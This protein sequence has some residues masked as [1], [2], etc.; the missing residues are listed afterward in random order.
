ML[1]LFSF[2][3]I[4]AQQ[5]DIISGYITDSLSGEALPG[6]H[7]QLEQT[8]V[9]TASNAYGFYSLGLPKGFS[10]RLKVSAVGYL[11]VWISIGSRLGSYSFALTPIS[12][13]LSEVTVS[14][15]AIEPMDKG[16]QLVI[17]PLQIA[18]FPRLLSEA[19]PLKYLQ[20]LPGIKMGREGSAGL[21]VRGGTPDQNLMVLDG[22]PIYNANHL[23]GYLSVFN[24]EAINNIEVYKNGI[25]ARYEGRL[26]SVIDISMKEGNLKKAQQSFS[27]SPVSGSLLVE[28][29][30]KKDTSSYMLTLR[31]TWLDG[32]LS[33]SQAGTG[34]SRGFNFFDLNAKFR[35]K[36]NDKNSFYLSAYSSRDKFHDRFS[37]SAS[38]KSLYS[39][40]WSNL[41]M[42]GRWNHVVS[43]NAFLNTSL[44]YSSYRYAQKDEY[45]SGQA[46]ETR[47]V[48]S[49]IKEVNLSTTLDYSLSASHQLNAGLVLSMKTFRPELIQLTS[50]GGGAT[51][52]GG[53]IPS[54]N[55]AFF[56]E[57][58]IRISPRLEADL[59]LR[60][61]YYLVSAERPR[62]YLQPRAKLSYHPA[63]NLSLQA[64]YDHIAQHLHLLT[65][66]TLGQPTDLWLPATSKAP[67][68]LSDQYTVSA[69]RSFPFFTLSLSGYYKRMQNV[70][71]YEQGATLLYGINEGWEEKIEL[72]KGS[73][74]GVE[75]LLTKTAG[76]LTG[77]LG[78]S[79]SKTERQF[80]GLN[81]GLPFPFKY[82]RRHDGSLLLSYSLKNKGK[83]SAYFTYNT[84]S[85]LTL[86]V[87]KV[88]GELPPAWAYL[89]DEQVV[90]RMRQRDLIIERNNA[91]MPDYHR[92]DLSYSHSKE[93]KKGRIRTWNVSIYNAYNRLNP[94]F[95]FESEG[96]L[97]QYA[98]FPVIPSVG[99]S[100]AF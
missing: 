78:Y 36:I 92:L 55:L 62:L 82:D 12:Y 71:E 3:G 25:P 90:E 44:F 95:I 81:N 59:G 68:E 50:A 80:T 49:S 70:I 16:N 31:R 84:G 64:S 52:P 69:I 86:P 87:G 100:L 85:A 7:L 56:A 28:G 53:R 83:L 6:A 35:H 65:N 37:Q 79:L 18:S 54:G 13:S 21:Y 46:R 23:F 15:T 58:H 32:L 11:P 22:V 94:Y 9:G 66:T 26:S 4:K 61:S 17:K 67:T 63:D 99:Y 38:D 33:L 41:T 48:N 40:N 45:R 91:R 73:S 42:L 89:N 20:S 97:K 29:P 24:L 14:S 19:D 74:R 1:L 75:L 98:F 93:K 77:H 30:I 10:N 34:K 96:K 27:L 60:A 51:T 8:S 72:G 47:Q 5:L 2:E 88:A 76:R 43:S 57:D 39:F